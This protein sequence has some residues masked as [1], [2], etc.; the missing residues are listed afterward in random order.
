MS[1][2]VFGCPPIS[3]YSEHKDLIANDYRESTAFHSCGIWTQASYINHSCISTARRSFIGDMMIVRATQDLAPGTEIT[4]WYQI[5]EGDL[6]TM[7]QKLEKGWGFTCDC[8]ICEHERKTKPAV[9]VQRQKLLDELKRTAQQPAPQNISPTKM[10]HLIT[11]LNNTYSQPPDKVPRLRFWAPQLFLARIYLD[12]KKMVKALDALQKVF[13]L[14]GFIVVGLDSTPT[15]FKVVKWG[16]AVDHLV[17]AFLDVQTAFERTGRY[18]DA[19][20]A[21]AYAKIVYKIVVG[22]DSSFESS[23][24]ERE[25]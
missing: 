1:L 24:S 5:P 13:T 17:E 19:K 4:F 11:T 16:M 2:N 15:V 7:Q 12:Q 21:E 20:A 9:V 14:L 3:T 25:S 18:V 23:Y 8:A 6:K 10:E 22:E